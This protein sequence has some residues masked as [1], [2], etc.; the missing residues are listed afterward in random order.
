M[1]PHRAGLLRPNSV[2]LRIRKLGLPMPA[3][4]WFELSSFSPSAG[5]RS[6]IQR[7]DALQALVSRCIH[8]E[9]LGIFQYVRESFRDRL[10]IERPTFVGQLRPQIGAANA[11]PRLGL[12][13]KN[14]PRYRSGRSFGAPRRCCL[15]A[16]RRAP[17][18][19]AME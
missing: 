8:S 7:L 9:K 17:A 14:L 3:A 10:T 12:R 15:P 18:T 11:S 6:Q 19:A 2:G 1:R 16:W 4:E 13:R 5:I